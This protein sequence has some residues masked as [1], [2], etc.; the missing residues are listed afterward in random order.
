MDS[1]KIML[2]MNRLYQARQG[3]QEQQYQIERAH[4]LFKLKASA[5]KKAKEEFEES[6]AAKHKLSV[7]A[8]ELEN[9]AARVSERLKKRREQMN[10]AKSNREYESIKLQVE[11]DEAKNDRLVEETLEAISA[12]EDATAVYDERQKVAKERQNDFETT[13]AESNTAESDAQSKIQDLQASIEK[14]VASLPGELHSIY[15][16]LASERDDPIAP[17]VDNK[18]CGACNAEL[19][20]ALV[21]KVRSGGASCCTTCGSLLF[22]PMQEES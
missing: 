22:I 12:L 5:L 11:L 13:Q 7:A 18:Y 1:K 6:L 14:L 8:L 20:P 21:I 10:S 15:N 19:P 9:E 2:L 3:V 17:V 4:H 16:R